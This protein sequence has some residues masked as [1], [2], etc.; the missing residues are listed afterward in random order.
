MRSASREP[1]LSVDGWRYPDRL[2]VRRCDAQANRGPMSIRNCSRC[3]YPG[4]LACVSG[5]R[6][7][8]G[9]CKQLI[10]PCGTPENGH[11]LLF[12]MRSARLCAALVR[13][14]PPS[15]RSGPQSDGAG[16]ART[17]GARAGIAGVEGEQLADQ[18]DANQNGVAILV[19]VTVGDLQRD[20]V[21]VS[22]L[23]TTIAQHY[24]QGRTG[25]ERPI[26]AG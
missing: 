23:A 11:A 15:G 21:F 5:G 17:A 18:S 19:A 8:L 9:P 25:A 24:R 26:D 7:A 6:G 14:Q 22:T 20:R 12:A 3:C 2:L 10:H 1:L 4:V 13:R 16:H